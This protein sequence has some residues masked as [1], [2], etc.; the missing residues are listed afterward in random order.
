MVRFGA[1][2]IAL[3]TLVF[4]AGC[5]KDSP[6]GEQLVAPE[7]SASSGSGSSDSDRDSDEPGGGRF[8]AIR[9]DC[10]P[11]DPMWTA[12]GG[13]LLRR[14]NVRFAEFADELDSPFSTAVVGHQAWRNDP[15]YL[16]IR[17][18]K[19]IRVRNEGG[20]THTF[21]KVAEFQG[22][23]VPPPPGDGLNKGL[24]PADECLRSTDILAGDGTRVSGLGV[25]NHRFQCCIHPWMRAIVKVKA[26]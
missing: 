14:G 3:V 15:P 17:R 18:G 24:V 6:S 1:G 22:G 12:L 5:S 8:I 13:C 19:T 21:T 10:D 4:V 7:A 25:G 2:C 20:R 11:T 26:N 23:K 16:V 9:D